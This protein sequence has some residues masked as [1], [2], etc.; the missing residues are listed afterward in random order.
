VPSDII[1]LLG[2]TGGGKSSIAN[3]ITGRSDCKEDNSLHSC[4]SS[5][6]AVSSK[7]YGSKESVTV[8]DTPG[9][10]DSERRDVQFLSQITEFLRNF[11]K[12]KLRNVV[13][14]LPLMET[15]AKS[16]YKDMID[17]IELLLGEKA[18]KQTMFITTLENQLADKNLVTQKIEG[19]KEW[20]TSDQDC[21]LRN[22]QH[23]N[24]V[25]DVPTS[26]EPLRAMFLSSKPFNP[27][28][29]EKIDKFIESNPSATVAEVIQGV[30]SLSTMQEQWK[31]KIA[32]LVL[33]KEETIKRWQN[34]QKLTER[35]QKALEGQQKEVEDLK[36]KLTEQPREIIR[37]IHHH[38][39]GGGRSC[40]L[41]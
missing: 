7:W 13:V 1:L 31:E 23:C 26:L 8:V 38:H 6:Q 41:M 29:S 12:N 33:E 5:L 20:L 10:L 37:E 28:T 25:Y 22:I 36:K 34:Q 40:I 15:R 18:W 4:T 35:L 24:F 27:E 32:Q 21:G 16:T 30:E 9:F 14:T 2:Q 17:E 39:S 11:P 19:W 3:K